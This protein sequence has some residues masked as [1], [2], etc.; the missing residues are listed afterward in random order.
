MH[1]STSLFEY[2]LHSKQNLQPSFAGACPPK[3]EDKYVKEGEMVALLCPNYLASNHSD[4][5][6]VWTAY[7]LQEMA[8]SN[9]MSSAKLLM[10]MG[11]LVHER[12]LVIFSASVN[13]QGNYSCSLG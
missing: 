2:I 6:L 10:Q 9:D 8:L 12:S 5:K 13:H 1:L 3:T 11:V 7:P 4:T